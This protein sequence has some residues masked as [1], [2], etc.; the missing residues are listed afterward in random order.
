MADVKKHTFRYRQL[1]IYKN[2]PL[3]RG[4][5]GAVYKAKCDQLPCA[6]KILHDELINPQNSGVSRILRQFEQ[7]CEFLSGFRHPH[8]VQYLGTAKSPERSKLPILIM[9]LLDE[10]LTKMLEES[11]HPLPYYLEVDLCHDIALAVSYLHSNDILHRDLSSNNVLITAGK[12][13]KITDFGM[14]RLI[15]STSSSSSLTIC[16]GAS[17]YMPPEARQDPADYTEKLDCYSQGVI[18][19]QICTRETPREGGRESHI[20][21]IRSTH[22]LLPIARRCLSG[23]QHERPTAEEL[24]HR[25]EIL[26]EGMEYKLSLL[27]AS[28]D[29]KDV[30]E[31]ER[32][33]KILQ[34]R[35]DQQEQQ[36]KEQEDIIEDIKQTNTSLERKVNDLLGGNLTTT[37][38]KQ[39]WTPG[40]NLPKEMVR[41]S[42]AVDGDVAYFMNKNGTLYMYDST[43]DPQEAWHQLVKCPHKDSCL[44]VVD[45]FLTAIGGLEFRG[46]GHRVT[47]KLISL[48]GKEI[49]TWETHFPPM[50]TK[51]Y[52]ATAI[53]TPKHL[54]VIGGIAKVNRATGAMDAVNQI[55]ILNFHAAPLTWCQVAGLS[56][57]F[58]K[59]SAAVC[60]D[61][62]YVMGGDYKVGL[63]TVL[64][65]TLPA[66]V[67]S[68][69]DSSPTSVWRQLT[70]V[71]SFYATCASSNRELLAIG[72]TSDTRNPKAKTE[73]YRYNQT[74]GSWNLYTNMITARYNSLVAVFPNKNLM[75]VVGGY[76]HNM[77][78]DIT[79][80]CQL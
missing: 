8:I 59:M 14:S 79:E 36:I 52:H 70:D 51:R 64:A 41:G 73:V 33:N 57:P 53:T 13:A 15:S 34:K 19:I 30:V 56:T 65:C 63:K 78:C 7:E 42:V 29:S 32:Q 49:R 45:S 10:N 71:P 3:G 58:C 40:R 55:E 66:L 37:S 16:P 72:G 54:V 74:D 35:L 68:T 23:S 61:Q 25:L 27:P 26:Q 69:R 75:V 2:Q 22:P 38:P 43:V 76:D 46:L 18:M 9:E 11:T 31:L 21:M 77:S 50:P 47:R 5:Y 67:Q 60:G 20:K 24:C 17:L 28:V 4:S 44:A 62:L 48:K 1:E 80:L 39:R 6:A 12:R